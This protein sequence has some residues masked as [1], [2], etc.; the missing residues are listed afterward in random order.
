MK[1]IVIFLTLVAS[2]LLCF[3]LGA[4]MILHGDFFYLA[5]QARDMLLVRDIVIG[6]KLTL[7][8]SHSGAGG[9]FH[10]PLWL[11]MLVPIFLI[12][13]GNPFV[14]TY[15]YI[16]IPSLTILAG[17]FVGTKLYGKCFG[18][19]VTFLL[20]TSAILWAYIPNT[21]GINLMPLLYIIFLY[22]ATLYIR[23]NTKALIFA[24][25]L[26]GL[27]FQFETASAL[28]LIPILFFLV[29]L[30]PN[31]IKHKKIILLSVIS[32]LVSLSNFILFDMR[33][34]FLIF[35]STLQLFGQPNNHKDYANFLQ[36][37]LDHLHSM[38]DTYL[39]ITFSHNILLI[40][41]AIIVLGVAAYIFYKNKSH[42]REFIFL[43]FTPL[44]VYIFYM[45]YPHPIYAEYVLD[46]SVSLLFAF[47]LALT[48]LSKH[49]T[50]KFISALFLVLTIFFA[51]KYL[52]TTYS[53]PYIP[54]TTG[55]S[56][57]NQKQVSEWILDNADDK[58]YSYFVYTPETF[59]Y[60]MDYLFW[61][62][63][64][65][66]QTPV[67]NT[68]LQQTYLI[69]YPHL[70]N[71]AHAY[72]FWIQNTIHTNAPT[73]KRKVFEGGIIVEKKDMSKDTQPVDPNY[74]QNLIFR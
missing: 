59:T 70:A 27:A 16:A 52:Y 36:R 65:M 25:F 58:P 48:L 6:H 71:D 28:A 21:I 49:T 22:P 43:F 68:K 38:Q 8:G 73:E 37:V 72:D 56:Y 24:A 61:W 2:F 15:W 57:L 66:H 67:Q 29:F 26:A 7:I 32:F 53:K 18:I 20:G 63:N 45:F 41:F 33:H 39:S 4:R 74:Y 31:I 35:K 23:G 60:G 40:F 9:L 51:G 62:E 44:L 5:D 17:F 54:D 1:K 46:L 11:Y 3:F 55:G 13:K 50:G 34:Q 14:F 19:I 64:S 12:G 10:G 69:L 47:S 30:N 42:L